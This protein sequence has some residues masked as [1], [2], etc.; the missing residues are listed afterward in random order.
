MDLIGILLFLVHL[1]IAGISISF[2]IFGT[3]L[4]VTLIMTF[5]MGLIWIACIYFDGCI[6]T[7]MESKLPLLGTTLT[8]SVK[9]LLHI[10]DSI[11]IKDIEYM[12]ISAAFA[13]YLVKSTILLGVEYFFEQPL[14]K[15]LARY[16]QSKESGGI[17]VRLL[18]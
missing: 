17:I 5:L 7:K 9:L 11:Q 4:Y 10:H 14:S 3:N 8:E 2:I 12:L 13:A 6:I 1:A 15:V 16:E 18:V